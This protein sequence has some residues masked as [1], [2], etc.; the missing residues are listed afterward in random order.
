VAIGCVSNATHPVPF[1][2]PRDKTRSGIRTQSTPGG[3]GYNELSFEDAIQNEQIYVHAQRDMDTLIERNHTL[4]VRGAE[5]H[6]VDGEQ[7]TT[8]GGDQQLSVMGSRSETVTGED[9]AVVCG[10]RSSE[11]QGDLRES[12]HGSASIAVSGGRAVQVDRDYSLSVGDGINP[13]QSDQFVHGSASIGASE[14]IVL[15]AEKGISLIVGDTRIEIDEDGVRI[16]GG[17]LDLKAGESASMSGKGPS[18]SLG[19]DAEI[20]SKSLR[21]YTEGA[22]LEMDKNAKLKGDKLLLNC[23]LSQPMDGDDA[24]APETQPFQVKLSNYYL[25][26]YAGKKYHLSVQG[27]R[28]EGTTDE[29]GLVKEDIPKDAKQVVVT[30]WLDEY[31]TGRQRVYTLSLGETPP[32]TTPRGAQLRLKHLG[33]FTGAPADDW[34]E[35]ARAALREI[36]SDHAETHGLDVTG[37]LD[38]PTIAMLE[39]VYGS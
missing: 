22:T 33:Y 27:L 28:F 25:A 14:R 7:S 12:V 6:S 8:V 3:T 17:K 35:E 9:R 34:S 20:T 37:E 31:P 36:Q 2:L 30:L 39:D 23:D 1:L 21:I 32:A 5:S 26:P 13:A 4:Q 29:D 10:N 24:A 15:R 11:V 38:G 19:E 16:E 18:L